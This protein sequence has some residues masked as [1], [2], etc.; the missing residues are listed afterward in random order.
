MI[1]ITTN[2]FVL[3]ICSFAVIKYF[4][5]S[6]LKYVTL[7]VSES[8]IYFGTAISDLEVSLSSFENSSSA[9]SSPTE[10]SSSD[11]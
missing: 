9:T 10:S 8:F 6:S 3:Y 4:I 1:R 2:Q 5:Y 11:S 7:L